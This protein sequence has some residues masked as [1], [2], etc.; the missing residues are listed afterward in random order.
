MGTAGV[1]VSTTTP[2]TDQTRT[3]SAYALQWNRFRIVRPEEDRATFRNRTGLEHA[4][5]SAGPSCSMPAAAWAAICELPPRALR[6]GWSGS[7]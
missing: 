6:D 4:A 7:T 1:R 2:K 3:K 5:T